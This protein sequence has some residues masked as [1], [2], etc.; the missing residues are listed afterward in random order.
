VSALAPTL[1]P[2]AAPGRTGTATR[3]E[4]RLRPEF[5]G[6]YPGLRV[7]EWA[8]AAVVADRVLAQSVLRA[9]DGIVRGRVLLET[10]FEFRHGRSLGGERRGV[11]LWRT[12][13]TA[14]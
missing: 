5:A 9:S 1:E 14:G 7:D 3:R 11:R 2:V 4:A 6:L 12:G 10:H 8:P 13:V